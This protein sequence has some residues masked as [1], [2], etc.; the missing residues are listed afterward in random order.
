MGLVS[1]IYQIL[2]LEEVSLETKDKVM[3]EMMDNYIERR[4]NYEGVHCPLLMRALKGEIKFERLYKKL[5][6]KLEMEPGI[7]AVFNNLDET[8]VKLLDATIER[9]YLNKKT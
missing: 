5:G 6:Q 9:L 2:K 4:K 7:L 3:K 1:N 8:S